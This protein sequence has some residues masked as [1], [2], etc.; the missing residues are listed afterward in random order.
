MVN[1][2]HWAGSIKSRRRGALGHKAIVAA[3]HRPAGLSYADV[4]ER[5]GNA[6]GRTLTFQPISEEEKRR[7][8]LARGESVEI[9]TAHLSIYAIRE[10]RLARVTDTIERVLGR[11]PITFDRWVRENIAVFREPP[12]A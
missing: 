1:A 4:T 6:I 12:A 10:G 11:K 2:L 5:I 9:I 8:M 7:K 3:D